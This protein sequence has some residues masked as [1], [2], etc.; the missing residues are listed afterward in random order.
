MTS[1]FIDGS[2]ASRARVGGSEVFL[3]NVNK[4][5]SEDSRWKEL[6]MF[7]DDRES[8]FVEFLENGKALGGGVLDV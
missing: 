8:L 1:A 2:G 5:G 6:K 7:A 3:L 4:V